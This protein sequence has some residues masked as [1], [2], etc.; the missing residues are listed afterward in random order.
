[1][2]TFVLVHGGSTG[3]WFW[4]PVRVRLQAA[5]HEVFAPSLTGMG[6]RVHLSSREIGLET[7]IVDVLNLLVYEDL[8]GVVLV[9]HSYGGMVVTSVADRV[10]ERIGHLVYVDAFVPRDGESVRSFSDPGGW[11][12]N[13]EEP[14]RARGDGWRNPRP[15]GPDADPRLVDHPYKTYTDP[16]ALTGAHRRVPT[17]YVWCTDPPH[18]LIAQAAERARAEPG[19]RFRELPTSHVPMRTMPDELTA[20][21]LEAAAPA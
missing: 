11:H 16:V 13:M 3:G 19:W 21:L 2:A 18:P 5:G 6:E 4:A 12:R 7:H 15:E 10:P 20:L 1:M 8:T 9:G 17:T 14:V